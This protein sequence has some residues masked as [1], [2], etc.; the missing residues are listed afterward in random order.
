MREAQVRTAFAD[1]QPYL[2]HSYRLRWRAEAIGRFIAGQRFE[3]AIDLGCGDGSLSIPF[4]DQIRG[5][6]LVDSSPAMLSAA[7]QKLTS[8]QLLRVRLIEGNAD[9]Q[10]RAD[11]A[12]LVLCVGLLAHV[13]DPRATLAN[14][15]RLVRP[16]GHVVVEHTDADHPYGWALIQYSRLRSRLRPG[17]YAW[18]ELRS[19]EVLS[20]CTELGLKSVSDFKYGLPFRLDRVLSDDAVYRLGQQLFGQPGNNSRTWLAC[21]RLYYFVRE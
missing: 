11:S 17:R 2:S 6:D 5:L 14:V 18:N 7:R 3:Q 8:E 16:G 21:E 15:A 10:S 20:W 9:D 19:S 12:D 13:D 4:L 1:P